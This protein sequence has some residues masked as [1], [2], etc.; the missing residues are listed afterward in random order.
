[1]YSWIIK[2]ASLIDGSGSKMQ[3]ADIAI[4]QDKIVAVGKNLAASS[5][6]SIVDVKG[7][8]LAPGFIDVQNHSDSYWQIFDNPKLE[9]LITQG[10]TTLLIGNSG[11]SLAPLISPDSLRSVQKWQPTTGLNV[12]WQTFAEYKQQLQNLSFASNLLSLVGYS[13]VRRGLLGDSTKTPDKAE[14]TSILSV[15]EKS[16]EEGASGISLG[17]YYSHEINVTDVEIIALAELCVKYDKLLSVALRNESDRIVDSVRDLAAIADQTGVKLKISH[18]KIRHQKNWPLLRDVLDIIETSWHRGTKIYFDC[19]PYTYTLQ[20][21][22]TYLPG[23]SLVGGRSHLL[24]K[25]SDPETRAKI[26]NELKNQPARLSELVIASTNNNI[27]VNGRTISQLAGEM[28]ITS[29]E[30]VLNLIQHGGVSTLVFDN[31]L[32]EAGT[33]ILLNHALGMIATNG[34]GYNLEHGNQ[35]VHPRSFGTSAKFLRQVIDEKTISLEE[36]IAKLTSRPAGILGLTDRGIIKTG[37][38]ADLVLFDPEKINSQANIQN[39]YQY[40]EGI[41]GVWVSGQ[42][43]VNKGRSTEIL[44]GKYIG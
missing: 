15:I 33:K 8:V 20:P 3:T 16:L 39:P 12:N 40:S 32:E 42:L 23:W 18:L 21:L 25:I 6:E 11:A 7:L 43:A 22:Y 30:A 35:L 29:E 13:T 36:A 44:A 19:Y 37:N 5:A 17:L 34:G 41:E 31:C 1:M 2:N 26:L 24:E 10:Y 38:I 14:L 4:E 9:S 28:Q 27:K